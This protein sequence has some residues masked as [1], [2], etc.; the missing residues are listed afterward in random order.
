M[1]LLNFNMNAFKYDGYV[2]FV[3]LP[4]HI[5]IHIYNYV[6]SDI[7][8]YK[9]IN[10]LVH[11][12]LEDKTKKI[13]DY[14]HNRNNDLT[15]D[16]RWIRKLCYDKVD[17]KWIICVCNRISD[18]VSCNYEMRMITCCCGVK[19]HKHSYKKHLKSKKHKLLFVENNK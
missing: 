7:R 15:C 11:K 2:E 17:D 8:K 6:R 13:Y 18:W 10:K 12:E 5:N 3:A 4:R 14:G 9:Q 19:V 16:Y 1:K